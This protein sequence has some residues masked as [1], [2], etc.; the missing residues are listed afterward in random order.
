M[1]LPS[2]ELIPL[3]FT[4]KVPRFF[5]PSDENMD[6]EKVNNKMKEK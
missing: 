6:T 2:S 3:N 1:T 4:T 5:A